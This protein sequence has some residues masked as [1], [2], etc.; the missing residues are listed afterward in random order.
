MGYEFIDFE[1]IEAHIA[2]VTLKQPKRLNA[3][4]PTML[5]ELSHAV[6]AIRAGS[7]R[8]RVAAEGRSAA[9]WTALLQR[10]GRPEG[11]CGRGVDASQP[12]A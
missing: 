11:S 4:N 6:D 3:I 8:S 7:R 12:R 5:G 9:R 2:A 10:R 1:K